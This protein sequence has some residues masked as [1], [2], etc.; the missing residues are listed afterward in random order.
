M[1]R[2]R[3][4]LCGGVAV[5]G[6]AF[7][8]HRSPA[9]KHTDDGQ[10]TQ[11]ELERR[12]QELLDS[13]GS[14]DKRPWKEYFADDC[15][16]F[17][18]KGRKMDKTALVADVSPLPPGYAGTLKLAGVESHIEGDV[19][20]MSYDQDETETVFGQA[21]TA[22]YHETDTWRRRNGRWQIVAAQVL[23]YYADPAPGKVNPESFGAYVG[24]YELAPRNR[25]VITTD[26]TKLFR[27]RGSQP[28]V[29]LIPEACDVFFR[30]GVEGR[31]VFRR[32]DQGGVDAL[33]DRRNNEDV[34]WKKAG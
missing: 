13:A 30:K 1:K 7:P 31:I 25:L 20:I 34:V 16:Y 22:R 19:A 21:M 3:G 2:I 23:R 9:Q 14:G 5:I 11:A 26:G 6:L 27:Q 33:I 4:L 8:A 32:G 12:T 15:F 10:I 24:T 18:E 28:K 29:E 17:D